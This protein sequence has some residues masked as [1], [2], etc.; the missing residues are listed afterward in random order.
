MKLLVI[1]DTHN[2]SRRMLEVA[3]RERDADAC[4]F[5]GD[6]LAGADVLTT[7]FSPS[8]IYSVQGNCDYD[9]SEYEDRLVPFCHTLFFITHG[10][11]YG[12]KYGLEQLWQAAHEAGAS[13]ALFGHSH[14]PLY[15][16]D[17]GIHLFN[18]G[19]LSMPRSEAGPTYGVITL[20]ENQTPQ[21]DIKRYL[22]KI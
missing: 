9:S 8:A 6:G 11:R 7:L 3:L 18:P 13:V 16:Y 4:I 5:L 20:E 14:T 15:E 12:V 10:H 22:N 21:F 1:A 19:S 2:S 17:R